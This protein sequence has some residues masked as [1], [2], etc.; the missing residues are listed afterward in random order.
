MTIFTCPVCGEK[1]DRLP[2]A[3]VCPNGHS[4]D[5]AAEGYIHL[6]PPNKMHSKIPGDNKE[7]IASRRR[8]LESGAYRLFSDKL[9]EL[10]CEYS[11]AKSPIILDAG[12]GEGYYTGRLCDDLV[13]HGFAPQV[14]GF[15]ISKFAVKAAAKKY[16]QISFAV[17]SSFGIPVSNGA[18]DFVLDVFAPVVESELNRVLKPGGTLILAVPGRR[19]L[20]GLKVILYD[21]PYENESIE[22]EYG[23]FQF[24]NRVPVETDAEIT[25]NQMIQDLFTMTPYYYKT[26]QDGAERL[27]Q[28]RTLQTHLEFDFLIYK[29]V[30]ENCISTES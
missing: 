20:Y 9:N 2:K 3:C 13:S 15:D 17:A 22:A 19:H 24:L 25:G 23:G 18:A 6:L 30:G 1:L 21:A 7:M 16:K 8:F 28:V 29:K 4:Y 26:G 10:V 11:P 27:K 14:F 5:L 12:C